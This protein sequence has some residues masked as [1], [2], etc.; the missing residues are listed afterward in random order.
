ME[1]HP[2]AYNEIILSLEDVLYD[3][4]YIIKD[5][6]RNTGLVVKQ[7]ETGAENVQIVLRVVTGDDDPNYKNSIISCWKISDKR[8][9]NYLRNKEIL[10]KKE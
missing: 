8:L 5:K 2:D 10:Y 6:H 3:P 1:R 4:D 7:L 9:E